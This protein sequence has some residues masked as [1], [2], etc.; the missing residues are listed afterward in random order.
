[1][2]SRSTSS[3][4]VAL[5]LFAAAKSTSAQ[6]PDAARRPPVLRASGVY[7]GDREQPKPSRMAGSDRET[8]ATLVTV[9]AVVMDRNGRYIANLR[10]EDFRIYEDGVEQQLAY[11]ASIEKPF[12]VAL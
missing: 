2:I 9:P 8:Q 11:F 5:L 6:S 1:M 4:L 3:L 7:A 12:T 10:K